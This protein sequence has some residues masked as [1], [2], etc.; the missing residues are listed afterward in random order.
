VYIG[1]EI[2]SARAKV[3]PAVYYPPPFVET[4]AVFFDAFPSCRER[5]KKLLNRRR[6]VISFSTLFTKRAFDVY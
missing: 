6:R 5:E 1:W 2:N 4:S 3:G